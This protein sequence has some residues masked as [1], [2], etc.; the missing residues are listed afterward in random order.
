MAIGV[1]LAVGTAQAAF[2]PALDLSN[3]NGTNGSALEGVAAESFAGQSVSAAGD[4]NGDGIDDIIVGAPY[5]SNGASY[6]GAGYVVFG[7]PQGL[8]NPLGLSTLGV[9]TGLSITGSS[10][11]DFVGFSV[12][13]AG[14]I[15][16]DGIADVVLGGPSSSLGE[17]YA[18]AV[19]VVFG[20]DQPLPVSL[21]V[22]S[23][24]GSNGFTILGAVNY[25]DTGATVSGA[26][27]FNG[28][29]IDDLVIGAPFTE[30][31]SAYVVFGNAGAW[32]GAVNL[33]DLNGSNGIRI[34]GAELAETLGQSVSRAGDV[35]G[36]GIDD[37]IVGAILAGAE[38][39]YAGA[40]YVVFGS[41]S[42]L[43]HP[44]DVSALD[45]SNGFALVGVTHGDFTGFSV[46]AAGDVNGDGIDDLIVG[47]PGADPNGGSSGIS[48]VVFGNAGAWGGVVNLSSLNGSNGFAILGVA[49]GDE[50][51]TAVGTAGDINNDGFD[52]LVIG[53]PLAS[54]GGAFSGAS[55]VVLG[56]NQA[57]PATVSLAGLTGANGFRIDGANAGDKSGT[58]VSAAGD[59]NLD[60]TPDFLVGAPEADPDGD[61]SGIA[62]VI[63]DAS[64]G[65]I[66]IIFANGFEN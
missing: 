16:G 18:G 24:T 9:G 13:S 35:N 39:D 11:S 17:D 2:L 65:G 26:G 22:S 52:D 62:Y 1:A 29:G 4:F 63:F 47:A 44:M 15:N 6:T 48:Y 42:G 7:S 38:G 5:S 41:D 56:S 21:S 59:L 57:W 31:G 53:A 60:A 12:A 25:A 61:Q 23:L 27:D 45:G 50:S 43:A 34:D 58:S 36:D 28:D 40:A 64:S 14:D 3:L 54:P 20:S 46:S 49:A 37:V 33:S 30:N 32:G 10:D 55:Y 51:G 66:E 8:P 19:F